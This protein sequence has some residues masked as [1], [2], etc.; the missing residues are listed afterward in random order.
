LFKIDVINPTSLAPSLPFTRVVASKT[1]LNAFGEQILS[2]KI[3]ESTNDGLISYNMS[4]AHHMAETFK[5]I[6]AALTAKNNRQLLVIL[7]K[8]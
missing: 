7:V 5:D 4:K 3:D 1:S 6:H 8:N 2:R